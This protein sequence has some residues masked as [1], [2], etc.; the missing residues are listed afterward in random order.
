MKAKIIKL[1]GTII[2]LEG[3]VEELKALGIGINT[4]VL[5]TMPV[6]LTGTFPVCTHEFDHS[7]TNP[8]CKKCG[9]SYTYNFDPNIT[10]GPIHRIPLGTENPTWYW[11]QSTDGSW[12]TVTS[13]DN[14]PITIEVTKSDLNAPIN[15]VSAWS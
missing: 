9:M 6:D 7:L 14:D 13:T 11:P 10:Y 4:P 1:D 2:E 8:T 5:K 15:I 3:T 12:Y